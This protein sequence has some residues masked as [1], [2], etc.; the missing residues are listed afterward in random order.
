MSSACCCGPR[1]TLMKVSF[2]VEGRSAPGN[3][4]LLSPPNLVLGPWKTVFLKKLTTFENLIKQ[5]LLC[6]PYPPKKV[7]PLFFWPKCQIWSFFSKTLTY[8]QRNLRKLG[9][10][11]GE[12]CPG[13]LSG[14]IVKVG[15]LAILYC[16]VQEILYHARH[17]YCTVR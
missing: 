8:L 9:G 10:G 15:S 5:Q 7:V 6:A 16:T 2:I 14:G 11:G 3:Q 12:R 4:H 13:L 1:Q 17:L